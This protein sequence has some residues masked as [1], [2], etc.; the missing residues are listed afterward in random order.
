MVTKVLLSLLLLSSFLYAAQEIN[1][2]NETLSNDLLVQEDPLI[3]KIKSFVGEDV[4]VQNKEFINV[5]FDPK[6]EFYR[7]DRVNSVKVIQTLKENG[8]LKLFFQ[9]P[10]AFTLHFKT[11]GSPL[12]FVKLM[13]D[14]LRNIGYFRYVTTASNL[15]ASEFIWSISLRSEYATDPLILQTE[16]AKSGCSIVDVQRDSAKEWTYTIDITNAELNVKL[17]QPK[18]KFKLKRS[19]YAYWLNISKIRTLIIKSPI[20]NSWY[21]NIA[22]YDASLHLVKLLKKD[23]IFRNVLLRMPKS[24]KYIKISD[25]YTLKNV[26]SGLRIEAKGSR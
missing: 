6:S 11:N 8:L 13:G 3:A 21:P 7:E 16:L 15:N 14:T 12:F 4:Y 22:Y 26:R 19:L 5:I 10:Q 17:V 24:A 2:R 9:T 23:K 20:R 18:E 1:D 25:L